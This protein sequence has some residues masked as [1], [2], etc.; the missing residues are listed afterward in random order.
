M[1][2]WGICFARLIPFLCKLLLCWGFFVGWELSL[3]PGAAAS[4]SPGLSEPGKDREEQ[5][6]AGMRLRPGLILQHLHSFSL[7]HSTFLSFT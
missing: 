5:P 1:S 6:Q 4:V 2:C 3:E 7:G